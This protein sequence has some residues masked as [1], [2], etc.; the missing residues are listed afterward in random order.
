MCARVKCSECE[1]SPAFM[2]ASCAGEMSAVMPLHEA[3]RL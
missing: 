2:L 1:L 3:E